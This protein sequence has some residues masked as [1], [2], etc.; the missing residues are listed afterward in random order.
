MLEADVDVFVVKVG[1]QRAERGVGSGEEDAVKEVCDKGA[2][3]GPGG[4]L[5]MVLVR[6][7]LARSRML[8]L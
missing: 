6:A 8:C 4:G 1:T 7:E 3:I 2:G 5:G